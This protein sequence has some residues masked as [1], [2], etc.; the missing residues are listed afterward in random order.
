MFLEWHNDFL[1]S[2]LW[3]ALTSRL[4]CERWYRVIQ[5]NCD[6]QFIPINLYRKPVLLQTVFRFPCRFSSATLEYNRSHQQCEIIPFRFYQPTRFP[7]VFQQWSFH[8]YYY[9]TTCSRLT[10][11]Q[12]QIPSATGGYGSLRTTS[13][14]PFPPLSLIWVNLAVGSNDVNYR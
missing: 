1:D 7:R 2:C 3:S 4:F 8:F 10:W 12:K 6:F 13:F 11:A 14:P 9:T 5:L